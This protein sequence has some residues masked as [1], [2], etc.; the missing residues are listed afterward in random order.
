MAPGTHV[1]GAAR[2]N[3]GDTDKAM[4]MN[5]PTQT[6]EGL[7]TVVNSCCNPAQRNREPGI[8]SQWAAAGTGAAA[9]GE[10]ATA[11]Q[12]PGCPGKARDE[13]TPLPLTGLASPPS[14]PTEVLRE[15]TAEKLNPV[16]QEIL[17][18]LIARKTMKPREFA[19]IHGTTR[20]RVK[21][22]TERTRAK[23]QHFL[24]APE[25]T[26]VLQRASEVRRTV[27]VAMSTAE[28]EEALGLLPE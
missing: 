8:R 15:W 5:N 23:L 26:P 21:G 4:T 10:L 2:N 20:A 14:I 27:Q 28:A 12:G 9:P 22:A 17:W 3:R 18:K 13:I 16:Q 25:A 24:Q 1:L 19:K 11:A 7:E 6:C